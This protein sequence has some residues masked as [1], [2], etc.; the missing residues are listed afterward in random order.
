MLTF[1]TESEVRAAFADQPKL[2]ANFLM[3]GYRQWAKRQTAKS[4]SKAARINKQIKELSPQQWAQLKATVRGKL[5]G[6]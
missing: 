4:P 3:A 6:S 5:K 1:T 2:L